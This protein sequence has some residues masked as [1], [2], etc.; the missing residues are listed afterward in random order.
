MQVGVAVPRQLRPVLGQL[1]PPLG[2]PGD[3]VEVEPP[4][5]RG[6]GEGE[7]ERG[8]ARGGQ[9]ELRG[10]G[11]REHDR[12]AERDDHEQL[13][14]LREVRGLDL[15]AAPVEAGPPRHAVEDERR[16][17]VDRERRQP[18]PRPGR[19]VDEPAREPERRG[20]GEPG[21]DRAGAAPL[22]RP[23]L[24]RGEGQEDVPADLDRDVG[25][26]EEQPA[27]GEGLGDRDREQQAAEHQPDQEQPD[28]DRARVELVRDPGRV[29]P[30]PPDDEQREQRPPGAAP[31]EVVEQQVRDLRDR[32]DE[33]EV[34]EELERRRALL[35]ALP[36]TLEAGHR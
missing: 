28:D 23:A 18:E 1:E 27:A 15:P 19:R 21:Q 11:A 7:D 9:L 29:V 30:G 34:V 13:E 2:D 8:R 24:R 33:D 20:R 26:G 36:A 4:E 32:E 16:R 14:P 5:R 31:G 10:R 25:A 12:L 22:D 3:V 35:A 17:V 6:R